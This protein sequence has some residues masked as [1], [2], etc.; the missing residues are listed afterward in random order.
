MSLLDT[1]MLDTEEVQRTFDEVIKKIIDEWYEKVA[2]FYV[3]KD[4]LVDG[5][6]ADD[7]VELKRFHDKNGHRIKFSKDNLDFTYGLRTVFEGNDFLIEVSVNNKVENFDYEEFR[8]R[9]TAHYR[10]T[11]R[12]L[13]PTPYELRSHSYHEIFQLGTNFREAFQVEMREGKADIMRLSFRLN[14]ELIDKLTSH[15]QS[16]KELVE[17]YCVTPFRNIYATVYRRNS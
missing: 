16:S 12:E 3:T 13:V 6:E 4:D 14:P 8:S 2:S 9:L 17:N 10:K 1:L 11:G 5:G 15:P 7:A